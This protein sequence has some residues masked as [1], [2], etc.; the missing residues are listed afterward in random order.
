MHPATRERVL[1]AAR[2]LNYRSNS[3]R[4]ERFDPQREAIALLLPDIGNPYY[5]QLTRGTQ[6]QLAAAGLSQVLADTEESTAVEELALRQVGQLT[7]GVV[8]AATRLSN[9]QLR[10]AARTT[11]LVL[12]NRV[13]DGFCS[14]CLDTGA[15]V[16]QAIDHLRSLGHGQV[17]YLSGP[18]G[19]W[20]DDVRWGALQEAANP[21][22]SA[23]KLGPFAPTLAAGAAAADATLTTGATACIAFN[24][25]LAIGA[26]QRFAERGVNVP[27]S[28]SVVGCD[29]IFGADFCSP[30][31]TTIAGD[32]QRVGRTAVQLLLALL[33][34]R[35]RA[36]ETVTLPTHL[37]VRASTTVP[38]AR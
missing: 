20:P 37:V 8:L 36:P 30:P 38:P 11:P 4:G 16:R 32:L 15:G 21:D 19:A 18:A 23:I 7:A 35:R 12:I 28:I 13:V 3:R 27:G 22:I 31:L 29:D 17:A 33:A 14:V 26:M 9:E 34:D 2:E 6:L 5:A 24:D 10:R 1:E 25:L